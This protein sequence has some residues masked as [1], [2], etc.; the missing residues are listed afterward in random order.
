MRIKTL[1][2]RSTLLDLDNIL[3]DEENPTSIAK[4]V[5]MQMPYKINY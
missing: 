2:L 3:A 5:R 4:K 1:M